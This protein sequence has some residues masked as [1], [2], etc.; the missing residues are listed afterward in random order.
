[1]EEID[2]SELLNYFKSKIIYIVFIASVFFCVSAI[3]VNRFRVPVYTSST[4]ILLN[5]ANE[6]IAINTNDLTLNKSL[7]PTYRE[8]IKS[9]RVLSQVIKSLDLDYEYSELANMVE[10]F[11]VTDTSII[12]VTVTNENRSEAATI[13]NTIAEVFTKEIVDIYNIEN[14]SIIDEAEESNKPSSTSAVKVV[15]I[16]TII[17]I[18]LAIIAFFIIYYF[19]TSIKSEEDIERIT[20]LPIIG[21]VPLSS[22]D[23]K[24]HS[25]SLIPAS[26]VEPINKKISHKK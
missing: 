22:K 9:K 8:I 15:L 21:V 1:M 3:Y 24:G 12:N 26:K 7:V 13:A 19:D 10:V 18:V 2:I 23:Q 25:D 14:I 17:G 11:E 5:Q 4:T 16:A 6:N 20:G